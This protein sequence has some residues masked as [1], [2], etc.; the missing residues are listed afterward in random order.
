MNNLHIHNTVC[1]SY[2]WLVRT[3][4]T[5]GTAATSAWYGHYQTLVVTELEHIHPN[6][7]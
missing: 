4:P 2:Q 7:P 1:Q 6:V 3:V 5:V